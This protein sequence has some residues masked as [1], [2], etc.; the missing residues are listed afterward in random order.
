MK[1]SSILIH[2]TQLS[3]FDGETQIGSHTTYAMANVVDQ[4]EVYE[5]MELLQNAIITVEGGFLYGSEIFYHESCI[6]M[7]VLKTLLEEG[8]RV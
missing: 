8:Y 2:F 7:E 1:K 5:E 4:N 6:Y 3:Y